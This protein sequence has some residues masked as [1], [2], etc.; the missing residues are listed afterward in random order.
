[1]LYASTKIKNIYGTDYEVIV[2]I[3]P[4][5]EVP[6]WNPD[7]PPPGTYL[8]PD[9]AQI[10]WVLDAATGIFAPPP[11]PPPAP[12]PEPPPDPWDGFAAELVLD[13]AEGGEMQG[14]SL[15]ATVGQS[16]CVTGHVSREGGIVPIDMPSIRLPILPAD[17][18]G[19][20]LWGQPALANARIDAGIVTATWTPESTGIYAITQHG[21][22]VR[23][24]E[25]AKL[26]FSGLTIFVV[27]GQGQEADE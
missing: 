7:N 2:V 22:N 6:A 14:N 23:L 10:G 24:P 17:V 13:G 3:K 20:A 5:T 1:M 12:E 27:Q 25:G 9:D 11:E 21:I 16:V 19:H 18:E 15:N 8:V 4:L 26:K